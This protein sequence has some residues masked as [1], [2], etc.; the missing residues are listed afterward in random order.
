MSRASVLA[1]GLWLVLAGPVAADTSV[2]D[3]LSLRFVEAAGAVEADILPTDNAAEPTLPVSRTVVVSG[4]ALECVGWSAD[5][6]GFPAMAMSFDADGTARIAAATE[7]GVGRRMALVV[8]GRV[9]VAPTV[10]SPIVDGR[11]QVAGVAA[12]EAAALVQ[13]IRKTSPHVRACQGTK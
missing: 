4:A 2:G 5:G 3:T 9:I 12:E 6:M 13:R 7:H 10:Y 8:D 11:M 1:A